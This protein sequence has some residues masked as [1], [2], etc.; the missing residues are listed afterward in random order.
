MAKKKQSGGSSSASAVARREQVRQ[1]RKERLNEGQQQNQAP[2]RKSRKRAP[3]RGPWPYVVGTLV[4]VAMVVG[5]FF[6]L[7]RQSNT[8]TGTSSGT[9]VDQGTLQQVTNVDPGILSQ[10]GTGSLSNP[11]KKPKGSPALLKGPTGKPEVFYYGA[12]YCPYCAA[13]RWS[14]IVALSRFGTFH[15]LHET[16]STASDVYP[17][18]STFTF[19]QS[20][21][22]SSYIDFVPIEAE[23]GQGQPLQQLTAEQQQLVNTYDGPPYTQSRGSF[24]FL[25]FGNRYMLFGASYDPALLRS[26]PSDPSSTPLSHQDIAGQLSSGNNLSKG[27]L[28]TANYMTAAICSITNNQPSSVCSDPSIQQIEATISKASA[29]SGG[30]SLIA[31]AGPQAVD[32]QRRQA[33]S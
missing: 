5:I 22:T 16:T 11:F 10:V 9:P 27:V 6:L 14:M 17:S 28:G 31:F 12:E 3:K 19:Y 13:E 21:Y 24:P 18:T 7:S 32:V 25:S 26:N 29:S 15:N 23:D 33:L 30:S 20:S 4:V 1:Q 8:T 2:V